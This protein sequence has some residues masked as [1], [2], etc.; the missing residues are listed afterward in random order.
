VA[1]IEVV[2]AAVAEAA[3][4]ATAVDRPAI[5]ASIKTAIQ[6]NSWA[7]CNGHLAFF[8]STFCMPESSVTHVE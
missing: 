5:T 3:A 8:F 6:K 7:R 4:E 2:A 1:G